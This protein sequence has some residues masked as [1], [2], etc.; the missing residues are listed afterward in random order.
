MSEA[1]S[2]LERQLTAL[3]EEYARTLSRAVSA[4]AKVAER[5]QELVKLQKRMVDGVAPQPPADTAPASLPAPSTA[6][7]LV[8][9]DAGGACAAGCTR[10]GNCDAV[11]GECACPFTH[12]GKACDE[13]R[14]PACALDEHETLNLSFLASEDAWRALRDVS[15]VPGEDARR[16]A[17]PVLW[18][19]PVTCECVLQAVSTLSLQASPMP[20]VWPA[21]IEHPFLSLQRVPCIDAPRATTVGAL[22]ERGGIADTAGGAANEPLP[23]AYLPVFAFLKQFPAHAP[24]LLPAGYVAE[25]TYM[26]PPGRAM[27]LDFS[28]PPPQPTRMPLG[29]LVSSMRR[30][31]L[32]LLPRVHCAPHGC[33]G[34]GWCDG[35]VASTG[36]PRCR[37]AAGMMGKRGL[38]SLRRSARDGA[39]GAAAGCDAR[40][41]RRRVKGLFGGGAGA[42]AALADHD[43]FGPDHWRQSVGAAANAVR[44][45][46]NGC[47]GRASRCSYGFCHCMRGFWGLDCGHSLQSVA[48]IHKPRPRVYVHP[49]PPALR[50]SCNWWHL[51][52]DVGE[53]LL[54]SPHAEADP[55]KADLFWIYGCPNGDT[56]LP[57]VRWIQQR[58]GPWWNASVTAGKP[59]HVLVVGHEEG[60]A[61]VW[62]YLVHWLRGAAGDHANKHGTWDALHPASPTRQL[63]I[64]QLSGKSDYPAAG[65][66]N[67]IRCVSSD[68]PC[69]VCFQPGKDVMVPGHPGLID[70]PRRE[71]SQFGSMGAYEPG[72]AGA[73][74]PR[75]GRPEVLFGG[76]VWTIPQGPGLY[77]SSRLVLYLCHKNASRRGHDYQIVQTETQPESVHRWEVEERID[78]ISAARQA[79]YCLVPEG[80]AGGYG[81][82]AIAYLMLGCV[83]IFSKERFSSAFFHEAINWSAISLH[84]PPSDMPRLPQILQA[85]DA[86]AMRAAASGVRRRLLWASIYG[87]CH[88]V[89]PD[90]GGKAD[91]FDTLMQVLAVPRRHFGVSA[92][93]SAPRAPE[94]HHKLTA[95]LQH[96]GG[97]YCAPAK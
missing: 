61:E 72:R 82:R 97:A 11:T 60:W 10:H 50:R 70:Y 89:G 29:Q 75:T 30:S 88:L 28:A 83:P 15:A 53:R 8:E 91:A 86:A 19:G 69:Y 21:Y 39:V 31:G 14:M 38:T 57:A 54:S 58:G 18:L 37:C 81:H 1:S 73:P 20:P 92:I 5:D 23:W 32:R 26:H 59:R 45:C 6:K 79:T 63:A 62:R 80:K 74:R 3:R 76:A 52:E 77:E 78:L 66:R 7:P 22:W 94:Q 27:D 43:R 35:S 17:P 48:S 84:V 71:C 4:E 68:A 64:V 36:P 55:A 93:H 51:P 2:A 96:Q 44:P 40:A 90:E 41:A 87:G 49:L 95:W 46:P 67:P 25:Q 85:S 13:P 47:S 9:D 34:V 65:E 16:T 24:M 12:G 33:N 56:I 42:S